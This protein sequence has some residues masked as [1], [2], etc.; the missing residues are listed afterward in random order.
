MMLGD[1][2]KYCGKNVF[3]EIFH[4]EWT[5]ERLSKVHS[6]GSFQAIDRILDE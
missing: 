2:I 4:V 6:W 3:W 1:D 5:I